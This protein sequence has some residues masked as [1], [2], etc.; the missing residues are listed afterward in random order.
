M[1]NE[2]VATTWLHEKTGVRRKSLGEITELLLDAK[3]GNERAGERLFQIVYRELVTLARIRLTHSSTL[4]NIDAPALVNEAYLR[5]SGLGKLPGENRRM[6]FGYASS[7][8][9]SVVVDYVRERA[10]QKR[11]MAVQ[12][13]TLTT[14]IAEVQFRDYE[15]EALDAALVDLAKI[16]PRSHQIVEMRYF[17]GLELDEIAD[18]LAISPATVKR[19]WQ[20]ARAFLFSA[21]RS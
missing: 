7:V 6:F 4:T 1:I 9:R 12:S 20:K 11:G 16:D 5:L 13:V 15:I 21:L 10:A 2:Y 14:G 3:A 8:M 19:D 17:G 18:A